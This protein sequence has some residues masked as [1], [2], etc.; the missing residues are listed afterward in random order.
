MSRSCWIGV[1]IAALLA[2]AACAQESGAPA[3]P[4]DTEQ[5]TPVPPVVTPGAKPDAAPSDALVLFDGKNLDQWVSTKDKSP[6]AW[7]LADG[8]MTVKKTAGNIETTI[9]KDGIHTV[10]EICTTVYADACAKAGLK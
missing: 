10:A 6:A 5:W 3:K 2:G 1:G 7:T 9:V 4:Q 8:V